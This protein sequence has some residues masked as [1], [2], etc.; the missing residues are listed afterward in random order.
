MSSDVLT[1]IAQLL[2]PE[3][4]IKYFDMTKFYIKDEE[5]HFYFTE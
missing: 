2:L 5:I 1:S 3:V 4:L